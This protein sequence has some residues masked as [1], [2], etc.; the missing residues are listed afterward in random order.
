MSIFIA[1]DIETTWVNN[2]HDVIIEYAFIKFDAK[3]YKEI[4]I[5][6]WFVNPHIPIPDVVKELTNIDDDDLISAP[7][8]QD[9]ISDIEL[10]IWWYPLVWHNID[11]DIWFLKSAGINISHNPTIDTFYLA[12][13][14]CSVDCSLSL[15]SLCE[16]FYISIHSAHR[17]LDDTKATYKLLEKLVCILEDCVKKN[18]DIFAYLYWCA[19]NIWDIFIYNYYIQPHIWKNNIHLQDIIQDHVSRIN[20]KQILPKLMQTDMT[21]LSQ[22]SFEILQSLPK[23]EYRESQKIMCEIIDNMYTSSSKI[24]VE[25]PT[26]TW[27]TFAYLIAS[28]LY[29]KRTWQQIC[30][31]TS[32]KILQ[33]QICEEDMRY[34]ADNLP[35]SFIYTKIMWK[36]NYFSLHGFY[37]FLDLHKKLSRKQLSF[38]IKLYLWSLSTT[39][40]EL[41]EL[42]FYGDEYM[43]L[44]SIDASNMNYEISTKHEN[45]WEFYKYIQKRAEISDIIVTNTHVIFQDIESNGT[46]FSKS[47]TL[48]CDEAHNLDDIVTSSCFVK[49]SSKKIDQLFSLIERKNQKHQMNLDINDLKCEIEY[50]T[51]DIFHECWKIIWSQYFYNSQYRKYLFKQ[52]DISS[53]TFLIHASNHL[54]AKLKKF[55][56]ILKHKQYVQYFFKEIQSIHEIE[57]FLHT[58]FTKIDRENFIYIWELYENQDIELSYTILNTWEYLKNVL[59]CTK[60]RILLTSATLFVPWNTFYS[61]KI[62]GIENFSQKILPPVFDYKKQSYI[63]IPNDLNKDQKL[64]AET[65]DF[66]KYFFTIV[67]WK[68]LMLCTSYAS[69]KEIY[70]YFH[71]YLKNQWIH[72]IAQ[73]FAGWR[74]KHLENYMKSPHNSILIGTDSFWQWVDIW[75]DALQYL[76]IYKLPFTPP[77]DPIFLARSWLFDNA[78]YDYAI[79]KTSI[80]L[81]QGLWRLIRSHNDTGMILFLDDRV[82]TQKWWKYFLDIFPP[83]IKIFKSSSNNLIKLLSE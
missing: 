58:F 17:A 28:L 73:W 80:K 15:S 4:D 76:I 10:F 55:E 44:W 48:I 57:T 38:F 75:W 7:D 51:S 46:I 13:Y 40:W 23:F 79:P 22:S 62:L 66:L 37:Q 11:F 78:F 34:L 67:W 29:S 50:I 18:P 26:W 9:V 49:F 21:K 3:T 33:D 74:N 64:N 82:V 69:I 1:L 63:F 61:E 60:D 36:K 14:L 19:E 42:E 77:S 54:I 6:T 45:D 16:Y 30:I 12:N 81:R 20:S 31:T 25:A 27:K 2:K 24:A 8:I 72:L 43:Y 39:Y 41:R 70:L 47:D 53:N 5:L 59:W 52:E 65:C 83:D 71:R 56:D 35:F 68:I 32:T